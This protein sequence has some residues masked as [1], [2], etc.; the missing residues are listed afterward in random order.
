VLEIFK[1]HLNSIYQ[2][3]VS[4]HAHELIIDLTNWD[5]NLVSGKLIISSSL[6]LGYQFN[7]ISIIPPKESLTIEEIDGI[8][9]NVGSSNLF[10]V[11]QLTVTKAFDAIHSKLS[12]KKKFILSQ[13]VFQP[14]QVLDSF[15]FAQEQLNST[16]LFFHRLQ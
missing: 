14:T 3:E 16:V 15:L 6:I 12:I 2:F 4:G 10:Q 8:A 11:L 1:F 13:T 7:S 5:L 9:I